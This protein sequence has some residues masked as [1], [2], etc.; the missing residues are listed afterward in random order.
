MEPER[1]QETNVNP[2]SCDDQYNTK[3]I[4]TSL[5]LTSLG[6]LVLEGIV[7]MFS[8]RADPW[9]G[10]LWFATVV[11]LGT[12]VMSVLPRPKTRRSKEQLL[13]ALLVVAPTV[14]LFAAC[15]YLWVF[16][17]AAGTPD[18]VLP[19]RVL[20][21]VLLL[22]VICLA[23]MDAKSLR[24]LHGIRGLADCSASVEISL[25]TWHSVTTS[26]SFTLVMVLTFAWSCCSSFSFY[27][28][29]QFGGFDFSI[30]KPSSELLQRIRWYAVEWC[31]LGTMIRLCLL[32]I[33]HAFM[34]LF[35]RIR[36]PRIRAGA[37][38]CWFALAA[39]GYVTLLMRDASAGAAA[40]PLV[41]PP[42][43]PF[44]Y[45]L[46]LSYRVRTRLSD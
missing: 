11:V 24:V 39:W 28:G 20:I 15:L 6:F 29:A 3:M 45:A 21:P 9:H 26:L 32:S 12:G 37:I 25:D 4:A 2:E 1:H 16:F 38:V 33:V 22:V 18:V 17:D 8:Q 42:I 46:L 41:V 13:H 34:V 5:A 40:I 14:H 10:Y 19:L 35:C 43:V 36:S 30:L 31:V 44:V 27:Y 7:C 23:T